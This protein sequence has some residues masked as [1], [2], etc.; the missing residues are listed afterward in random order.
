MLPN[1]AMIIDTPGMRELGMW[2]TEKGISE[3]FKDI[4]ELTKICKFFDCT[5]KNE[6]GCKILEAIENG[7]LSEDRFEKYLSL[8]KESEYNTNSE[9]Y[10]KNKHDKFKE[11]SKINKHKKK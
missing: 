3:T 5:H 10:L 8:K 4:K 2:N 1:G 11:I 9:Q 7:E 6:P